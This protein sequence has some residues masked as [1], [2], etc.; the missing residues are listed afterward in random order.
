MN[1]DSSSF[2]YTGIIF[3]SLSLSGNIPV[4]NIW[5]I[6]MVMTLTIIIGNCFY[7]G[8]SFRRHPLRGMQKSIFFL[9]A[10]LSV[11][12]FCKFTN[13]DFV[14]SD[15]FI[16]ISFMSL[17][18]FIIC[19]IQFSDG[20]PGLRLTGFK[21][22]ARDLQAGV[23]VSRQRRWHIHFNLLL[24]IVMFKGSTSVMVCNCSFEM[25]LGHV[26]FSMILSCLL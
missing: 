18:S 24:L 10:T 4:F 8:V 19:C 1:T 3:A 26:L 5:L 9:K 6:I 22:S 12:N 17:T 15:F 25:V 21:T 16:S 2:L 14:L 20:L 13:M 23:W 7:F 11:A